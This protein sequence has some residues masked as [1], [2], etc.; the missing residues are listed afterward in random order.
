MVNTLA[1]ILL[2]LLLTACHYPLPDL[3]SDT[4]T[5]HTK[6]SLTYLHERHYTY[7]TNFEVQADSVVL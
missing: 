2:V 3:S 5:E 6:D 7:N 1:G 4:L